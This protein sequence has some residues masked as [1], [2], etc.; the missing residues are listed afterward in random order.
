MDEIVAVA[1]MA[2]HLPRR[3]DKQKLLYI[4]DTL[5]PGSVE[6]AVNK[7]FDQFIAPLKSILRSTAAAPHSSG[8]GEDK[9]PH[10]WDSLSDSA[11]EEV[12]KTKC[13]LS[14]GRRGFIP[15]TSNLCAIFEQALGR[16]PHRALSET[17]E[18][19]A[20]SPSPSVA[21][22]SC[23][24]SSSGSSGSTKRGEESV[25]SNHSPGAAEH[26]SSQAQQKALPTYRLTFTAITS[27]M[28]GLTVATKDESFF[29]FLPKTDIDDDY[30]SHS[31]RSMGSS[32][33]VN[34]LN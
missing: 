23:E 28:V 30:P 26:P 21:A 2:S 5:L 13:P 11:K 20:K 7:R 25:R 15:L 14:M 16:K 29:G 3:L 1:D 34:I 32:N 8:N 4:R 17:S 31:C 24:S 18:E 33:L 6:P 27:L 22:F 9:G 10:S 19:S 12:P